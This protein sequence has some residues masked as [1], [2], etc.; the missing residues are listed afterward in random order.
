MIARRCAKRPRVGHSVALRLRRTLPLPA[1]GIMVAALAWAASGLVPVHAQANG[2]PDEKTLE[3]ALQKKAAAPKSAPNPASTKN[4]PAPANASAVS[5][6]PAAARALIPLIVVSDA[7]CALEV[8][9]DPIAALEP[10]AAKK[11]SVFPGD[12]LV[13]CAST[14]EPGE[15]YS[16]VQNIKADEQTVLQ[17]GLASRIAAVRQKRDAEAQR[18]SAEDE[19]WQRAGQSGTGA[20]LQAYL[21]KYPNGR[22]AEQAQ[23]ILAESTR[24]AEEDAAWKR[25]GTST[26]LAAVQSYVDKYPTGRYLDAAQQRMDFIKHL[27][28][29]PVLPFAVGEEVWEALENSAFYRDLPRR[30]HKVTVQVSTKVHSE[31][32]KGSSTSWNQVTTRDIAPL[33]ERCVLLHT[34][35]RK[36]D[37]NDAPSDVTDDY[38]CGLLKLGT[39][40]NGKLVRTVSLSDAETFLESDKARR[41]KPP[42]DLPSSGPASA[43][44]AKLTGTATRYGCAEGDYYFEDLSVWLYELGE[45]DPEKQQYIVPAPGYHF[46]S[47]TDGEPGGRTTTTYD[48][49]AWTVSN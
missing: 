7:A 47:V 6:K 11:L 33:G 14:E 38:Q 23:G 41:E 13:K 16:V 10:G 8:N 29:R 22:Y 1:C 12:Q 9:G 21:D 25:A 27:P 5:P 18:L 4:V 43:F 15:V 20:D 2:V 3:D 45:M 28:A 49:F 31:S 40:V 42:C 35:M 24:R 19:L 36:S 32:S 39:V 37:L 44:H 26:Q 48:R 30:S 34:V 17:I 46:E